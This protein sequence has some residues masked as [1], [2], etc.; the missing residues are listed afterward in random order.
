[1]IDTHSHINFDEYK[2]DFDCFLENLKNNEIEKV[3][4]PSVE[5]KSFEDIIK[6]C[7]KHD[8]LYGA[9]GVHPSEYKTYNIEVEKEI[10][11]LCNNKKIKAIGEI[12]LDYY[13]EPDSKEEQKI[14]LSKQL[15]I[16]EKLKLPVIIHDRDAHEDIFDI[17]QTYTL[18]EVVMHCFSGTVDFAKECIKKDYYIGVGGIVT[19]KNAKDLQE[20]VKTIPLEKILLETDAPYL[21]PVPY[22]GK[23]NSPKYL[24]YIA[25]KIAE[26][27]GITIEEVKKQTTVNAKRIFNF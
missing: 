7:N 24:K 14:I 2:K 8:M 25:E 20:T 3:I 19:F 12:G 15:E 6:L 1:M 18:K 11:N 22:R 5:P 26:I 9:I 17:L 13:Y 23:I 21:A 27:K 10:Y 4:I 16:A